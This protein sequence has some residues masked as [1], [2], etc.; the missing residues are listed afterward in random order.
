MEQDSTKTLQTPFIPFILRIFFENGAYKDIYNFSFAEKDAD[1]NKD[2]MYFDY[3]NAEYK[4]DVFTDPEC[5]RDAVCQFHLERKYDEFKEDYSKTMVHVALL[6]QD[7]PEEKSNEQESVITVEMN[8]IT[9]PSYYNKSGIEV[10]D[11]I[12]AF[13][14]DLPNAQAFY[15]GNAI[16]HLLRWHHKN[17]VEDLEKAKVYI[18]KLIEERGKKS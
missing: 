5:K 8:D 14:N 16:K 6:N 2:T 10:W 1:K 4:V 12:N 18:D 17:G 11:V 3:K 9:R 13:C 7:Y 15:A